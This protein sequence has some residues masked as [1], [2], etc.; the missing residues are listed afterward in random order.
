MLAEANKKAEKVEFKTW[1][2]FLKGPL[3]LGKPTFQT[4]KSIGITYKNLS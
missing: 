4:Y 1:I 2:T 3:D